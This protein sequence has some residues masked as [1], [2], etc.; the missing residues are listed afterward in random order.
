MEKANHLFT[1]SKTYS[2]SAS[3]QLNGLNED[4]PCSRLHGHNYKVEFQFTSNELTHQGFVVDVS[5]LKQLK[6][7]IRGQFDHRHL[8]EFME[9]TT[10]EHIACHFYHIAANMGL[11]VSKVRVFETDTIWAEYFL[12]N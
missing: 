2:F 7:Y 5:Q 9:L 4:H 10:C 11:P 3:H 8:N 6:E 12:I 1:I